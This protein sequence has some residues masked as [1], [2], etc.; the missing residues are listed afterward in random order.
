MNKTIPLIFTLAVSS[1]LSQDARA[2]PWENAAPVVDSQVKPGSDRIG[3]DLSFLRDRHGQ[4]AQRRLD[5]QYKLVYFGA[6]HSISLVPGQ[7]ASP[8]NNSCAIDLLVLE[9]ARK[10]VGRRCGQSVSDRL[11]ALF[12]YPSPRL[13]D[14]PPYNLR[15]YLDVPGSH[16]L[17]LHAPIEDILSLGRRYAVRYLQDKQSDVV[18]GHT[19]FT[20]LM[21]PDGKNLAIFPA[22]M[23]D[24]AGVIAKQ[25]IRS[26]S[27]DNFALPDTPECSR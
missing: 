1:G 25:I 15:T 27:L 7:N 19:R 4:S 6:A 5:G 2:W 13:S 14:P 24:P 10:E 8:Q 17:G 16:I 3:G 20:Y 23:A 9:E 18:T 26:M 22:D 21:G 11:S 12:I